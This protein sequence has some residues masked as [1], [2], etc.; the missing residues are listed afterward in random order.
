MA[1]RASAKVKNP[2]ADKGADRSRAA[3]IGATA[4][5]N[6]AAW[7]PLSA[8]RRQ[9]QEFSMRFIVTI[10]MAVMMAAAALPTLAQTTQPAP[11]QP[12]TEQTTTEPTTAAQPADDDTDIGWIGLLGLLGLAGLIRRREPVVLTPSDTTAGT[13]TTTTRAP[14]DTL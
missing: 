1:E 11:D 14:R 13:R 12:T 3:R 8:A 9:Y 7:L 5:A 6:A 10:T 4:N 2:E